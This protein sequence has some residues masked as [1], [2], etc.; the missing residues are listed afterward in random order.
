MKDSWSTPKRVKRRSLWL[1]VLKEKKQGSSHGAPNHINQ[2]SELPKPIPSLN[3][4][5]FVVLSFA[6]RSYT[7]LHFQT[8][9]FSSFWARWVWRKSSHFANRSSTTLNVMR[10]PDMFAFEYVW[11]KFVNQHSHIVRHSNGRWPDLCVTTARS[12]STSFDCHDI[13]LEPFQICNAIIY[14]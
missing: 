3:R 1:V 13:L 6:A 2:Y 8:G 11:I 12:C 9:N 7:I 5:G 10:S 14:L 4:P